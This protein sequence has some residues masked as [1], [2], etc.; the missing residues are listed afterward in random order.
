ML[1]LTNVNSL[2]GSISTVGH[3]DV[4]AEECFHVKSRRRLCIATII[5]RYLDSGRLKAYKWQPEK[6]CF[7]NNI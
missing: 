2:A 5:L 4:H 1:T 3:H 6:N 7:L